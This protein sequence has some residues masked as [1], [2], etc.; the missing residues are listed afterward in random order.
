M[1]TCREVHDFLMAW[2]DGEL[3]PAVGNRFEEHIAACPCCKYYLD[4][5]QRTIKLGR[6]AFDPSDEC[7]E[8]SAEVHPPLPADLVKAVLAARR[9]AAPP[10]DAE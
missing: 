9:K 1:T 10:S 4:S 3:E 5:Y 6:D 2:L 7:D 8:E